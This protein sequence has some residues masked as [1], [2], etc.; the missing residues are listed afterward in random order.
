LYTIFH[1][2]NPR[3]FISELIDQE[4]EITLETY[5]V[6]VGSPVQH[7]IQTN[8]CL[9]IIPFFKFEHNIDKVIII[10]HNS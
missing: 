7:Y 4:H 6:Q 2:I 10:K 3:T 1:L 8:Y 9:K 5:F